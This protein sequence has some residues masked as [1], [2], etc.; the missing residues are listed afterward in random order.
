MSAHPTRE[1]ESAEEGVDQVAEGE[2][3]VPLRLQKF[4]ARAGVGSRR[5]SE[6]LMTAGRVAVNGAIVTE[7]GTKV[8]PSVDTVTVDGVEVSAG[9]GST[10]LLL[11]KPAG[12]VTTMSDPHGRPTVAEL[13]PRQPAGLFPVG[14][15]DQATTGALLFTTDGELGFR[16]LHPRYHVAKTYR[17]LVDGDPDAAALDALRSGV[18]LDDG[19][20]A[21]AEVVVIVAGPKTVLEM[22]I[23]EGRKRQVRRMCSAVG[24]PVIE[25]QRI[26]F[27]PIELGE[28]SAGSV[29]ALSADEVRA[30][31]AAAGIETEV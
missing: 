9:S 23:R 17:V 10:Y 11:N 20:T 22:T 7:L 2:R 15:L 18:E 29:R 26:S 21:P 24:R 4:L 1:D 5:G 30:L 8:D 6:D 12:Y 19:R 25:L 3:V 28:L 13:F 27:G 31:K 14:R 16:L